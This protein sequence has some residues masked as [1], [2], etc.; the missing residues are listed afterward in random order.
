MHNH[1]FITPGSITQIRADAIAYSASTYL[2]PDGSLYSSF[3]THIPGFAEWY[4]QLKRGHKE[5][6]RVGQTF[7]MP[8]GPDRP[9]YGVVVALS[10]GGEGTPDEKARLAVVAAL[11]RAVRE[12]R[13]RGRTD[14]LLIALPTFRVGRGGDRQRMLH[15]ARIQVEAALEALAKLEQVD[16]VFV[17]Y[18]PT[19][20]QVFLEARRELRRPAV[21]PPLVDP[22]HSSALEDALLARECVLF[23]GAGLSRGTGLPDWS[24]LINRLA[25]ELGIKRDGLDYLDLAQWYRERFGHRQLAEVIH[26]TYGEPK[27]L[28]TLAHYLLLS[29]PVRLVIT[30]N[31][32]ELLEQTLIALKRYPMK[33]VQQHDVTRIGNSQ[34]TYVVKLHGDAA[35]AEEIVLSRDDY[36]SFFEKRPAMALLLEGLLLNHSFFFVGYSLRDPNFRQIYS[37][38][39]RMLRDAA[40]PAFATSFE[41][42]SEPGGYLRQQWRQK[43]LHLLTMEGATPEEQQHR[44][45]QFL[46]GLVERV[47]LHAPG[48]MLAPDVAV[49]PL[50]TRLRELLVEDVGR[51]M[52]EICRRRLPAPDRKGEPTADASDISHLAEVLGF[53]TDHGW[54]PRPGHGWDLGRMWEHLAAHTGNPV[55]QRR[56]LVRALSHTEA[57]ADAHRIRA[58]LEAI[59]A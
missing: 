49:S 36:D 48:L 30:T 57:L 17:T 26:Q 40:R 21:S 45:L 5:E 31:Y 55:E 58:K 22:E 18:T 39:A 11:N 9:P 37:R 54:K 24:E 23:V 27:A 19:L 7:W 47:T 59:R 38:I 15:S 4:K 44:F 56:L 1:L 6:R 28:P 53:L 3:Q 35:S 46:D 14:R 2:G 51:E 29:L 52:E 50:L 20:Y 41:A 10:T 16:A 8:L 42:A 43:R 25:G 13:A 32:D 12:L 34:G 33:V